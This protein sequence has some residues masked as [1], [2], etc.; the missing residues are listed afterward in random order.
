MPV[1]KP[2]LV[3]A[4][5]IFFLVTALLVTPIVLWA[6]TLPKSSVNNGCSSDTDCNY[7]G[8][9][10]NGS[11][12]CNSPWGGPFCTVLGNLNDAALKSGGGVQCSQVPTPCKTDTDCGV[13]NQDD[14]EYSCQSVSASQN[15]K[16]LSGTFCLPTPPNSA[17]LTGVSTADSIPGFYTWQGWA[18]VETQAWTCA[19]EFPNFYPLT[20][21]S[22]G[23]NQTVACTKS[24]QVCQFGDWTYPC[25]RDPQNPLVCLN[26]QCSVDSECTDPNQKCLPITEDKKVCQLPPVP[27]DTVSD[28]PG[29]GTSQYDPTKYTPDQITGLCG[30]ACVAQASQQT[31]QVDSNCGAYSTCVNGS[32]VTKTCQK[33]C[34]LNSDCGEY[35][36]VNGTCVTSPTTLVG[37]NPFEYGLCDCSNQ[38][39][40]T[41]ADC[42]G[43]CLNGTCVGQRVV[44]GPDGAP[45]CVKDTCAPGGIFVPVAV[46]PYTFGYCDCSTDYKPQGNTCAYTG[47]EPPSKYCALGCGRG[48]CVAPGK[49]SCPTG[50]KGNTICTKFS[51]DGIA[52]GCGHGTC[53][54]PN[55]CAC[56]PGYTTDMNGACTVAKS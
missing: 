39:C 31:C 7:H 8:S 27:C 34:K 36:C 45:T 25:L 29:C 1:K 10:V 51:C 47:N 2:K 49:C 9:C 54:G 15:N 46:P 23:G 37:A 44:M 20:T 6:V 24:P 3:A 42:A 22:S 19:C 48:K 26:Q 41:D 33:T 4:L 18:D 50:W 28:C 43:T 13:C 53:I 30:T 38:S 40:S 14:I 21:V 56:D 12:K 16:G 32:C 55:T 52:G 11:C 35:P 5:L 17:C